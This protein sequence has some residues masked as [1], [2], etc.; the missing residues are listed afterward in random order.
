MGMVLEGRQPVYGGCSMKTC[1]CICVCVSIQDTYACAGVWGLRCLKETHQDKHQQVELPSPLSLFPPVCT[2]TPIVITT[3]SLCR[4][5]K[6]KHHIF[7]CYLRVELCVDTLR[8]E[9][10]PRKSVSRTPK[11]ER[12]ASGENTRLVLPHP[13]IYCPFPAG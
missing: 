1:L 5:F 10:F 4:S 3:G 6:N 8:V 11:C 12:Q 13:F 2:K 7:L 9:R